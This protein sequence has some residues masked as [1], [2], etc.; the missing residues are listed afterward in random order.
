[1]KLGV[2]IEEIFKVLQNNTLTSEELDTKHKEMIVGCEFDIKAD[3][4]STEHQY[5]VEWGR[6]IKEYREYSEEHRTLSLVCLRLK[7]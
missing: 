6:G 3:P 4:H 5:Q 1:M 2:P 7:E